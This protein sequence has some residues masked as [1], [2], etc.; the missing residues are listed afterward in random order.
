[1]RELTDTDL[2]AIGPM[3]D[4]SMA[5]LG[6]VA[7]SETA[8]A[9]ARYEKT[10]YGDV[11]T[12][13]STPVGYAI[14]TISGNRTTAEPI[15]RMESM[16]FKP[17]NRG[18]L[19]VKAVKAFEADAIARGCTSVIFGVPMSSPNSTVGLIEYLGYTAFEIQFMK[20]VN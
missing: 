7:E 15:A 13:D 11:Y 2:E 19:P 4:A 3:M 5:E 6:I 18:F 14:Y 1:M 8:L 12:V 20:K 10:L 9:E 17:G 16:Y